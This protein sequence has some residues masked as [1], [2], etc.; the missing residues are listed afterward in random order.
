V[1]TEG[2]AIT[3]GE[4]VGL[5]E[6]EGVG[7]KEGVGENEGPGEN[8]GEGF[9]TVRPTGGLRSMSLGATTGSWQALT[10][11]MAVSREKRHF[12]RRE[13]MGYCPP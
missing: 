2:E 8:E 12:N 3:A 4:A 5:G 11:T 13:V 1:G 7:E 9:L 6:N 10:A